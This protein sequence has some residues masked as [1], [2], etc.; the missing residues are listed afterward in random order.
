MPPEGR[1]ADKEFSL[2]PC[3][4]IVQ[5]TERSSQMQSHCQTP[6]Q[7]EIFA[8]SHFSPFIKRINFHDS[9]HFTELLT[10]ETGSLPAQG[11]L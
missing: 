2:K 6:P 8:Q 10:Q 3:M 4:F 1:V 9:T 5:T 11:L 7:G